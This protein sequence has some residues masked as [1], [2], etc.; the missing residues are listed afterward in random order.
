MGTLGEALMAGEQRRQH[1]IAR[2]CV[3]VGKAI[4]KTF[5]GEATPADVESRVSRKESPETKSVRF[6][7]SGAHVRVRVCVCVRTCVHSVEGRR[8]ESRRT[9]GHLHCFKGANSGKS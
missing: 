3:R 6:H 5:C 9:E 7:E 4:R 1:G 2:G 8:Q